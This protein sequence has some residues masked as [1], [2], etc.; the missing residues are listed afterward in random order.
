MPINDPRR[1]DFGSDEYDAYKQSGAA[2][3]KS[4]QMR[5]WMGA[6]AYSIKLPGS[7][8][9]AV[10]LRAAADKF[11]AGGLH[12]AVCL[13][14]TATPPASWAMCRSGGIN[15]T[16]D[17]T[18]A[19]STAA[20]T[21][22]DGRTVGVLAATAASHT[23][24]EN[25]SGIVELALAGA[26]VCQY[27]HIVVSLYDPALS[28]REYYVEGSGLVSGAGI[29]VIF[30][31]DGVEAPE[32]DYGAEPVRM[33]VRTTGVSK[34]L[35]YSGAGGNLE[36]FRLRMI[37]GNDMVRAAGV[38]I[39]AT[40]NTATPYSGGYL[41]PEVKLENFNCI[42][43]G[44]MVS[45]YCPVPLLKGQR[46]WL[47]AAEPVLGVSPIRISV[48]AAAE[49]PDTANSDTW[50]G[51]GGSCI[52]TGLVRPTAAGWCSIP[53]HADS[54]S[55]SIHIIAHLD[56]I[57]A[58]DAAAV[59]LGF[60]NA[61]FSVADMHVS[62]AAAVAPP[63]TPAPRGFAALAGPGNQGGMIFSLL[64]PGSIEISG[65]HSR[66]GYAISSDGSATKAG[67]SYGPWLDWVTNAPQSNADEIVYAVAGGGYFLARGYSGAWYY[68]GVRP[69]ALS[70]L[71]LDGSDN[72]GLFFAVC[73]DRAVVAVKPDGSLH[74]W[75]FLPSD[76]A[77]TLAE[78]AIS[79][80]L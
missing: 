34:T 51:A 76:A 40:D 12:I 22:E 43:R 44:A 56:D 5:V 36:S 39:T 59:R 2:D 23:A 61:G 49:P 54:P 15:A 6:A 26:P 24:D 74:V 73:Q 63:A 27:M 18:G 41:A 38:A 13:S 10:R 78:W 7:S 66:F 80:L 46:L 57:D 9:S 42:A 60:A 62:H 52:A 32:P 29:A 69:A 47:R 75:G 53:V 20:T 72:G 58:A 65:F 1:A 70:A 21:L 14:D 30:A 50:H 3:D 45:A 37:W 35:E 55:T 64:P 33:A 48:F 79:H 17:A 19:Y 8:V 77:A 25:K 71:A 16:P 68:A 11:C 67:T 4:G 31:A 28:R